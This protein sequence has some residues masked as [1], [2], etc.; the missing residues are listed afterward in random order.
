MA[1]VA[2]LAVG[3]DIRDEAVQPA[4]ATADRLLRADALEQ[5]GLLGAAVGG[6]PVATKQSIE[7]LE[8]FE[9]ALARA[10]SDAKPVLVVCRASWCRWSAELAQGPLAD[11]RIIELSRAFI[12]VMV[13]ADRNGDVCRTLG[14]QAFPTVLVLAPDGAERTRTVGRPTIATLAAALESTLRP[15]VAAEAAAPKR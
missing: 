4:V 11:P 9:A 12:C 1:G 7:Y 14:V 3:C 15:T 2:G 5:G 10:A 8:G 6:P 13:D